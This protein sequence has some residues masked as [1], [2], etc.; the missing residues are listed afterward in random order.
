MS[1]RF[2]RANDSVIFTKLRQQLSETWAR[3]SVSAQLW[4]LE[5]LVAISQA[6]S[7]L[8]PRTLHRLWLEPLP[9]FMTSLP[10]QEEQQACHPQKSGFLS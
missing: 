1:R 8:S 7:E 5:P 4:L 3:L 9:A 6:T 10:V 2:A